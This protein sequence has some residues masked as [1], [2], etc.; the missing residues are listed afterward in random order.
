M[1]RNPGVAIHSA[2]ATEPDPLNP[3]AELNYLI[4]CDPE[5]GPKYSPRPKLVTVPYAERRA[6]YLRVNGRPADA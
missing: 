2:P 5:L 1:S 6:E 3:F 4:A